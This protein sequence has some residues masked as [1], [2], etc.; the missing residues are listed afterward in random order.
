[1]RSMMPFLKVKIKFSHDANDVISAG[2]NTPT[3]ASSSNADSLLPSVFIV[4]GMHP[5]T[6]YMTLSL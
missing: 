3:N 5:N 2:S 1:M 4:P 6:S